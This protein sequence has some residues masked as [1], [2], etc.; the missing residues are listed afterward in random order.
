M[1]PSRSRAPQWV[2]AR[3]LASRPARASSSNPVQTD[4]VRRASAD[5]CAIQWSTPTFS[6]SAGINPPG[7]TIKSIGG[8]EPKS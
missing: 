7:I 6:S 4:V 3:R 2:V 5:V 8:A 1:P